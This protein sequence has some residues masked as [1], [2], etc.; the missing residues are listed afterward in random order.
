MDSI[1]NQVKPNPAVPMGCKSTMN[2]VCEAKMNYSPPKDNNG[3]SNRGELKGK[4]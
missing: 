1:M 4:I 3:K 2:V